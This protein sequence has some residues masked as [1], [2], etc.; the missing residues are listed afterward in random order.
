MV[1][2][3]GRSVPSVYVAPFVTGFSTCA[4]TGLTQ[5]RLIVQSV[6]GAGV[7]VVGVG[8]VG[9]GVVGVGVVGVGEGDGAG[10]GVGDGLPVNGVPR[11]G[12][13]GLY[14]MSLRT[15]AG[16]GSAKSRNPPLTY[17]AAAVPVN[18]ALYD[19]AVFAPALSRKSRMLPLPPRLRSKVETL[20][21][22]SL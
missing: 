21:L 3:A 6:A 11:V 1:A 17:A 12:I 14:E 13:A 8:V 2:V 16:V 19:P 4:V 9:V 15:I 20:R 7:G 5:F 18:A 22:G 10:V